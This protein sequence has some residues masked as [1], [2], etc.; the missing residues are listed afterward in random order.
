MQKMRVVAVAVVVILS[1]GFCVLIIVSLIPYFSVIG[2]AATV[3]VFILLGCIS[4][5]MV[6]FTWSRIGVW[7]HRRHLL[8]AG[9]VVAYLA[10]NGELLHLSAT[11]EAARSYLRS[12]AKRCPRQSGRWTK[13]T[14]RNCKAMA[15]ACVP[16][17]KAQ[18]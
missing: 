18:G 8:I 15:L 5:L 7:S 11:H 4:T 3:V 14:S 17:R 6:S 1:S 12:K 9:D 2:K 16:L 10:P 13:R